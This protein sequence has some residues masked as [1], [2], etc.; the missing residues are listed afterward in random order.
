[1]FDTKE[2]E[3]VWWTKQEWSRFTKTKTKQISLLFSQNKYEIK[4]SFERHVYQTNNKRTKL[5]KRIFFLTKSAPFHPNK[6]KPD[7]GKLLV[8]NWFKCE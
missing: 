2:E 3:K 7:D 8:D 5:E 6:G 4:L 1:M